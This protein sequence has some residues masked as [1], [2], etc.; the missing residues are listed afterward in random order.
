MKLKFTQAH[1]DKWTKLLD[2]PDVI[3]PVYAHLLESKETPVMSSN[4]ASPDVQKILTEFMA[5]A[6]KD[7]GHDLHLPDSVFK[8]DRTTLLSVVFHM[9]AEVARLREKK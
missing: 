6:E 4:E 8:A 9:A 3:G 5:L 2:G 1:I 7:S